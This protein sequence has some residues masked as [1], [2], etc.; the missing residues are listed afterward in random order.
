MVSLNRNLLLTFIYNLCVIFISAAKS[1]QI[2][3][4]AVPPSLSKDTTISYALG[5][6]ILR[7]VPCTLRELNLYFVT[8]SVE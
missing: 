3:Q 6:H 4:L 8:F 2:K 5:F 7:N 1:V